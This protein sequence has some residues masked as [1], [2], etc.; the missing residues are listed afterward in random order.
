MVTRKVFI[1]LVGITLDFAFVLSACNTAATVVP[2]P[3]WTAT[4]APMV[5]AA[6]ATAAPPATE[7]PIPTVSSTPTIVAIA[8]P[9]VQP[10]AQVIPSVNAY[11]RRGPGTNYDA[12][13]S[14]V[15]GTAY[16]VIGRNNM[17]TWWLVQVFGGAV[18]CWVGAPGTSLVGPVEQVPV[19]LA[20]P[21][22]PS[23]SMFTYTYSCHTGGNTKSMDVTLSWGAVDGATGYHLYRNSVSLARLGAAESTY[24]D[25]NAPM[26]GNLVYELEAL[27][28][29]GSTAPVFVTVL[30]CKY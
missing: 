17:N 22:L 12:V 11:C 6:T 25:Y 13:T 9:T 10:T 4:P 24:I 14:V 2:A 30:A 21:V 27:N 16:N 8:T 1:K 23:P 26:N 3:T 7:S 15:G 19:A 29:V 5:P 20:Q 18:T 28:A